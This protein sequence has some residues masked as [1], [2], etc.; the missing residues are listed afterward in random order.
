LANFFAFGRSIL[1]AGVGYGDAGG[2][3]GASDSVRHAEALGDSGGEAAGEA[4]DEPSGNSL[5]QVENDLE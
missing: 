3:N 2:A 4:I 5:P 1:S